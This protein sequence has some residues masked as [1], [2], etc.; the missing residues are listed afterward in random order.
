[1]PEG[2]AVIILG[3]GG[4]ATAIAFRLAQEG[5]RQMKILSRSTDQGRRLCCELNEKLNFAAEYGSLDRGEL[6]NMGGQYSLVINTTPVGMNA[7]HLEEMPLFHPEWAEPGTIFYDLIYNPLETAW[8]KKAR[9]LG[10]KTVSGL[11]MLVYQGAESF[12]IWTGC[13]MPINYVIS[14]LSDYFNKNGSTC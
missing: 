9:Q 11:G 14:K 4:A 7:G 12:R 10:R 5:L 6:E 3:A 2:N 8:L 13:E 1:V